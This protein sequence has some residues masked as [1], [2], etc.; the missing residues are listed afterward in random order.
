L[1]GRE[2]WSV[3]L[4]NS[5]VEAVREQSAEE[6]IGLREVREVTEEL[7]I[8]CNEVANNLYSSPNIIIHPSLVPRSRMVE[9]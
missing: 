8:F 1:C 3:S 6:N 9:L 4:R 2:T 5:I 7:K